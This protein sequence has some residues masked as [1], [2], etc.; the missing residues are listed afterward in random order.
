[1]GVV[2][3]SYFLGVA[4]IAAYFVYFW[5]STGQAVGGR[6]MGFQVISEATGGLLSP[7]RAL[8]R[9]I[10]YVISG[11]ILCLGFLWALWDP[12]K[13]GWHDKVAGSVVIPVGTAN[14]AAPNRR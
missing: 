14:S 5:S 12:K 9:Y 13:Q 6:I 11:F 1:V 4:E 10:G 8:L 3:A 7:S 2:Y